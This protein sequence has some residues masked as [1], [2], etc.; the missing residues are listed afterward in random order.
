MY[1]YNFGNSVSA[2]TKSGVATIVFLDKFNTTQ[3]IPF[4]KLTQ[5]GSSLLETLVICLPISAACCGDP[6]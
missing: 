4:S 1:G 3:I 6:A 5:H 2:R